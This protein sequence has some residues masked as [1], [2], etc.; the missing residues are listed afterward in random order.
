MKYRK[1]SPCI[2]NDA[3][4]RELSDKATLVLLFLLT[5]PHMTPLGAIRANGPG[6]ACELGWS[7][8]AFRSAFEEILAQ[9]IVRE[10]TQAMLIWFPNFLKHNMPESPNVVKSWVGAFADLPESALKRNMLGKTAAVVAGLGEGF[11]EAFREGFGEALRKSMPNQEQEQEQEQSLGCGADTASLCPDTVCPDTLV[12]ARE[13]PV[14][15][16]QGFES[17]WDVY[18][19]QQGRE[20]ARREWRRLAE[21]REL[22]EPEVIR[23]AILRL[24]AEDARWKRG[25]V[26]KMG[27]WLSGK[28]WE[29]RPYARPAAANDESRP[30]ANTVAQKQT[31]DN[32]DMAKMLLQMRRNSHA[33]PELHAAIAG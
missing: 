19:V 2:W 7:A 12:P 30:R 31:Q 6:L 15:K 27:K 8:N 20:D 24:V 10:D 1:I 29:D 13:E 32:D 26:P 17:C 23:A 21:N 16:G 25:M 5:H 4:V 28:G 14:P 22:A 11:R 33:Q 3:K 18:P 9:G